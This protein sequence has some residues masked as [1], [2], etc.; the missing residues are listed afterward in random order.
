MS[1]FVIFCSFFSRLFSPYLLLFVHPSPSCILDLWKL[2][3]LAFFSW[4]FDSKSF[5]HIIFVSWTI[6]SLCQ[7]VVELISCFSFFD[8]KSGLWSCFPVLLLAFVFSLSFFLLF[9]LCFLV[10]SLP[11][12][13]FSFFLF[14]IKFSLLCFSE[15]TC[16]LCFS[17]SILFDFPNILLVSSHSFSLVPMVLFTLLSHPLFLLPLSAPFPIWFLPCVILRSFFPLLE[18]VITTSSSPSDSSFAPSSSLSIAVC[19]SKPSY[20]VYSF[21][22]IVLISPS[23]TLFVNSPLYLLFLWPS[24]LK[25]WFLS[26]SHLWPLIHLVN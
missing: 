12:N 15:W 2:L 8:S 21:T 13:V 10:L 26:S 16:L 6:W 11:F 25:N 5:C 24:C 3:I 14:S 23:P 22:K 9:S 20:H 1:H 4:F 19:W 7:W 17:S 18:S